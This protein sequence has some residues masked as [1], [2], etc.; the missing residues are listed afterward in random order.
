MSEVLL[1]EQV[2]LLRTLVSI[3]GSQKLGLGVT[4]RPTTIYC[5]RTEGSPALWYTLDYGTE[6]PTRIPVGETCITG[7][8]TALAFKE[9]EK[10]FRGK[11][12]VKLHLTVQADRTYLLETGHDTVFARSLMASL[13]ALTPDD[14]SQPLTLEV[15]P[16][17]DPMVLFCRILRPDGSP[18]VNEDPI[19]DLRELAVAALALFKR[20]L[21]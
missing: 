9:R 21:G 19:S 6:T 3:L 7:Y 1:A 20:G 4:P 15:Q 5:S 18:V 17:E 2:Q 8:F 11:K 13:T 14:L 16:G 12:V 10:T